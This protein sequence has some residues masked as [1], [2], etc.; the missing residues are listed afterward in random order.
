MKKFDF[1]L[2]RV[3]EYRRMVEDW[4]RQN[5]LDARSARLQAEAALLAIRTEQDGLLVEPVDCVE[6]CQTLD[7]RLTLL[8]DRA[9]NQQ[10]ALTV[11]ESEE[12]HALGVWQQKQ[13]DVKVIEK[14]RERKVEEWEAELNR[15][16][17]GEL[18]E[19]AVQRR[20]S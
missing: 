2:E 9:S 15:M 5:F 7:L 6:D 19:W 3:L 20:A 11:L 14:L 1:R 10:A 12:A 8:D 18:D 4:A 17:Q 16:E 13:K